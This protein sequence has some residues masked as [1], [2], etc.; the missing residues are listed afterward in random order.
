VVDSTH[1]IEAES[2]GTTFTAVRDLDVIKVTDIAV[3]P[4]I[5]PIALRLKAD[6]ASDRRYRT[7]QGAQ[8]R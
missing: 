1:A 4:Q 8:M 6:I 3:V 7:I 2:K 5:E